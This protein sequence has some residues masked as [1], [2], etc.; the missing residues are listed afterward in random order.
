MDRRAQ[1]QARRQVL[2]KAF[3]YARSGKSLDELQADILD[4]AEDG[5]GDVT[6]WI[7]LLTT[8]LPLLLDIFKLFRK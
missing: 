6:F 8:L 3:E 2:S 4:E 7:M 5:D 1:R